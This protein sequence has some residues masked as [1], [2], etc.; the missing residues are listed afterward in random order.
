M[1]AECMAVTS[2]RD[3]TVIGSWLQCGRLQLAA[4]TDML[5]HTFMDT[6]HGLLSEWGEM[7]RYR[8][9]F[10]WAAISLSL[11]EGEMR[12]WRLNEVNNMLENLFQG[13]RW[14]EARLDCTLI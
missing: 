6:D 13:I 8:A 7:A 9:Q 3:T 4:E 14:R 1:T 5:P 12:G 11:G 10:T 2:Q